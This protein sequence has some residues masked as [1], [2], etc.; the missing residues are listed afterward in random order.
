MNERYRLVLAP[1]ATRALRN[2]LKPSVAFSLFEFMD[3]VICEAPR[4]LGKPLTGP[5]DGFFSARRGAYR[6][7]YQIDE[8]ARTVEVT[9]VDHRAD[10]YRPR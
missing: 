6:V 3:K 2:K 5:F 7:V 1:S 4:R 10:V 9:T 8:K